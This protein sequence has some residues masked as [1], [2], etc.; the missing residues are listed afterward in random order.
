MDDALLHNSETLDSQCLNQDY[1]KPSRDLIAL[2]QEIL[3]PPLRPLDQVDAELLFIGGQILYHCRNERGQHQRYFITPNAARMAFLGGTFD[4]G[5]IDSS[6]VR[7][8]DNGRPWIVQFF[9]PQPYRLKVE[10]TWEW[11]QQIE[12]AIAH[13]DLKPPFP[14]DEVGVSKPSNQRYVVVLKVWL[15][16]MVAFVQGTQVSLWA[17][18]PSKF[19]PNAILFQVP[20]PNVHSSG[21]LCFGQ[22]LPIPKLNAIN[23]LWERWWGGVFN[24][25]LAN[26]R[27]KQFPLDIRSQLVQLHLNQKRYPL[28]DLMPFKEGE[29]SVAQIIQSK[30]QND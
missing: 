18:K 6:I 4:T 13:P 15:P 29:H 8:G 2:E 27:S 3:Q 20:I 26:Q 21:T 23:Q 19:D 24:A 7:S 12:G 11:M 25:D 1:V 14:L 30:I 22:D 10:V 17:I 16:G 9:P 28:K 5:W